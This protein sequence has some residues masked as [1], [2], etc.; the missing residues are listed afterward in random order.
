LAAITARP[1]DANATAGGTRA[2]GVP[3]R[4]RARRL[5]FQLSPVG[6]IR[7]DWRRRGPNL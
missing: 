2:H 6:H 4:W 3:V 1:A 7:S 5:A